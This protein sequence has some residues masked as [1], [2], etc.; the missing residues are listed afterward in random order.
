MN[1]LYTTLGVAVAAGAVFMLSRRQ[2]DVSGEDARKLVAAGARLLDV[3]SAG[4]FRAGHV[5]GAVN[6]PVQE[7][8]RR[9][10]EVGAKTQPVVVYCQSGMRSAQAKRLLESNGF[11]QVSDLGPMS[12]W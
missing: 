12:R 1:L 5:P 2:G 3:R 4:E 9:L 10:K 7:L 6:I 11:T 8:P